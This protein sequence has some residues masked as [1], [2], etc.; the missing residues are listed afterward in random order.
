MK[1]RR[2]YVPAKEAKNRFGELLEAAQ[3]HPI[4]ITK[5]NRVVAEI[6][7]SSERTRFEEMEDKIWGERALKAEKEGY[8]GVKASKKLMDRFR[9]A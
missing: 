4:L 9:N 1:T 5:N 6:R 7:R 2:V 3:R 8:I